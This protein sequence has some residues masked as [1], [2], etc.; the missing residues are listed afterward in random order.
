MLNM[1]KKNI[2]ILDNNRIIIP[3]PLTH[4]EYYYYYRLST[5]VA[6]KKK[7]SSLNHLLLALVTSSCNLLRHSSL[8][9]LSSLLL[10]YLATGSGSSLARLWR[11]GLRQR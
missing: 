7:M 2:K 9:R 1:T 11:L 10:P 4:T 5:F 6:A 8:F 3:P